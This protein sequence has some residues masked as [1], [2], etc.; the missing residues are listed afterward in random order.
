M[1][2]EEALKF[3]QDRIDGIKRHFTAK[4][5]SEKK[6]AKETIEFLEYVKEVLS[7]E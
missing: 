6:I 2:R 7:K 1:N 3:A 5:E 4:N